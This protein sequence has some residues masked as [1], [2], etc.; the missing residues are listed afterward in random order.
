MAKSPEG[1]H[2]TYVRDKVKEQ[3]IVYPWKIMDGYQSGVPDSFFVNDVGISTARNLFI[4][5]KYIPDFPKRDTTI[6][7]PK[8][9]SGNQIRWCDR[10]FNA[11]EQIAVVIFVGKGAKTKCIWMDKKEEWTNGVTTERAKREAISRA[12][13][14]SRIHWL[15]T[16]GRYGQFPPKES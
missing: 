16:D 15:T 3:G 1:V 11:G 7:V 12:D 6:I 8:W 5:A 4:E 13:I 10:L 14:I 2:S 9:S